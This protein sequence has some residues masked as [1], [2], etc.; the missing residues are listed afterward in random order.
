MWKDFLDEEAYESLLK[1]SYYAIYNKEYNIKTI[2]L[3]TQSCD[4]INF[5][6]F[7]DSTDLG[8]QLKWLRSELYL[9]EA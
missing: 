4:A 5:Y 8:N 7:N 2:V 1:N 6:A 9:S 3:N